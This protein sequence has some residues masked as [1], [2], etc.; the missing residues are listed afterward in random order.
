MNINDI[1]YVFQY[2]GD[3]DR[4]LAADQMSDQFCRQ[5]AIDVGIDLAVATEEY[6]I[7]TCTKP[8]AAGLL[9]EMSKE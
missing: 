1:N 5:R 6:L 9:V 7:E 3:L 2:P 8:L 4:D